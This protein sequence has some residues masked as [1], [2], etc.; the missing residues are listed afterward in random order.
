MALQIKRIGRVKHQ[1][2]C[3]NIFEYLSVQVVILTFSGHAQVGVL[4][5]FEASVIIP[6]PVGIFGDR[7]V[8][9]DYRLDG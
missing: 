5:S 6:N 2:I 8:M 1:I 7:D 4:Q 9:A 3:D